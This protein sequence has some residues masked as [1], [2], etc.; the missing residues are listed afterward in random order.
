[1]LR[2]P[3]VSVENHCFAAVAYVALGKS[4]TDAGSTA[5]MT[6]SLPALR[7]SRA[8]ISKKRDFTDNRIFCM[9]TKLVVL[10]QCSSS[11][12]L[13]LIRHFEKGAL[14][15]QGLDSKLHRSRC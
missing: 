13:R 3:L 6:I 4:K 7:I 12:N 8:L 1:M 9:V 2:A 11:D 15:H 10:V 14:A 5:S